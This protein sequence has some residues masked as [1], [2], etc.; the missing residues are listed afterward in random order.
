MKPFRILFLILLVSSS[1]WA[2]FTEGVHLFQSGKLGLAKKNL[3]QVDVSSRNWVVA[4]EELQKI[5]YQTQNWS[6]FFGYAIF[7]RNSLTDDKRTVRFSQRLLTLEVLALARHC[8]FETAQEIADWAIAE[9]QRIKSPTNEIEKAYLL[10]GFKPKTSAETN[11]GDQNN[12]I[13]RRVFNRQVPL[14]THPL[15]LRV[16][17]RNHCEAIG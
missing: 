9:G 12:K 1:V 6:T 10:L 4:A 7:Y 3:D 8:H 16:K 14:L 13:N 17:V 5:H 15:N 11:L 2:S